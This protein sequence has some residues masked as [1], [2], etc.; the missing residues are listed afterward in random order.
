MSATWSAPATLQTRESCTEQ[1]GTCLSAHSATAPSITILCL[2]GLHLEWERRVAL[3]FHLMHG[4]G[5]PRE[6]GFELWPKSGEL[7]VLRQAESDLRE[8]R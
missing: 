6:V 8:K 2:K 5:Q 1:T 4:G 3:Q 7:L